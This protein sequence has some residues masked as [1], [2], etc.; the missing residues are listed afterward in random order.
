MYNEIIPCFNFRCL[1]WLLN[2]LM[3]HQNVELF[4]ELRY[5]NFK[6]LHNYPK[7][8]SSLVKVCKTF[9]YKTK[10]YYEKVNLMK[11]I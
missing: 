10:I 2:N 5:L 9:L 4:K 7:Y 6:K 1:E 11:C 3:T 8:C